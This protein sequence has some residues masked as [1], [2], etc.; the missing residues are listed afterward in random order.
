[1]KTVRNV[2]RTRLIVLMMKYMILD[3]DL[4]GIY[5]RTTKLLNIFELL[6]SSALY[7]VPGLSIVTIQQDVIA[8]AGWGAA[9]LDPP[10]PCTPDT[11]CDIVSCSKILIAASVVLLVDDDEAHP[12]V[13]WDPL[14]SELLPD[15]F[16][17]PGVG[18]TENVTVDDV[19]G[20]WTGMSSCALLLF[21]PL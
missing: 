8:T 19:V 14:I 17:M 21:S 16:V 1:M 5:D 2:E 6:T 15:D 13:Q 9:S 7:H 10:R 4:K 3:G 11:F 20:H 12:E 18:H